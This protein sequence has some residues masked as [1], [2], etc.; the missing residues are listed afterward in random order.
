MGGRDAF[1]VKMDF[2]SDRSRANRPVRED[3]PV[4]LPG[5]NAAQC[6]ETARA[7]GVAYDDVTWSALA[8]SAEQLG[9]TLPPAI[10]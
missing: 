10:A 2:L 1:G 7:R 6:I 3:R 5:D 9:V 4:R 8:R